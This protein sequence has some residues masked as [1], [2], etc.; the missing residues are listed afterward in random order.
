MLR[1]LLAFL[2]LLLLFPLDESLL[3]ESAEQ[4]PPEIATTRITDRPAT[5]PLKAPPADT[6]VV[7]SEHLQ[8]SLKIWLSYRQQQGHRIAVVTPELTAVQTKSRILE[9]TDQKSLR[10]ILLVGDANAEPNASPQRQKLLVPTFFVEAKVN[11]QF[12]SEKTIA[13]DNPYADLDDDGIPDVAIGRLTADSKPELVLMINKIIRYESQCDHAAWRRKINFVAGMGGFGKLEDTILE[14]ATKQFIARGIP[15]G[16]ETSMTYA[17]WQSPYCP[18]PRRF[19]DET[20]CRMNDGCLMWIY[21]GH[22]HVQ[23]LDQMNV[24]GVPFHIFDVRDVAK[25][26]ARAGLPIAVFLACYT[27]AFDAQYDCLAEE[28]LRIER[29]PVAVLGGTRVTLPYAMSVM[30]LELLNEYFHG[31]SQ[32]LGD[33]VLTAKRKS[34]ED[35]ANGSLRQVLDSLAQVMSPTKNMLAEE[36]KENLSIFHLI[37]DPLLR[38][39]R[40]LQI[41]LDSAPRSK[42]GEIVTVSGSAPVAGQLTV[43]LAYPRDRLSFRPDKRDH[44]EWSEEFL[45]QLQRCYLQANNRTMRKQTFDVPSGPFTLSIPIP[46]EASGT[47]DINAFLE[48]PQRFA[49]GNAKVI[50]R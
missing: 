37:G 50:V 29:G 22:G 41:E 11:S 10:Y 31:A 4:R 6:V 40:P 3:N 28:L 1:L 33:V 48:S 45:A 5:I 13:S 14:T 15:E 30:S 47:C 23:Q 18:D 12:G 38:I 2:S 8:P 46:A 26:N 39:K 17:S 34:V 42:P 16:Y 43:E 44:V 32:T 7:C 19:H 49:V 25:V 35:Q 9:A 24:S 20:L 21:I 27:A 36:R